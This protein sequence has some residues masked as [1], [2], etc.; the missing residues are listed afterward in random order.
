M[1]GATSIWDRAWWV[2]WYTPCPAWGGFDDGGCRRARP[3]ESRL[4]EC[5]GRAVLLRRLL[6]LVV[7][8]LGRRGLMRESGI[9]LGSAAV[10]TGSSPPRAT[11]SSSHPGSSCRLRHGAWSLSRARDPHLG[12]KLRRIACRRNTSRRRSRQAVRVGT[13]QLDALPLTLRRKAVVYRL[14][15]P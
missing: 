13:A 5:S 9:G 1:P 2:C 8:V 3:L 6:T 7:A 10:M 12:G 15:A 11:G 14:A 4:L